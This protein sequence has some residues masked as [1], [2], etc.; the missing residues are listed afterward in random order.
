MMASLAFV[1]G[2]SGGAGP[3]QINPAGPPGIPG[4]PGA[5][6][7]PGLNGVNGKDGAPGLIQSING[8][9]A[10]AI[11]L[12]AN[13]IGAQPAG[14]DASALQLPAPDGASLPATL[15]DRGLR[16]CRAAD[17]GGWGASTADNDRIHQAMLA[18]A[19][20]TGSGAFALEFP[21][22]Q[23][24]LTVART[25]A[26]TKPFK[27]VT[28]GRGT[29]RFLVGTGG[30]SLL[31]LQQQTP[32]AP[33]VV[34]GIEFVATAPGVATPLVLAYAGTP[35]GPS[36]FNQYPTVALRDLAWSGSDHTPTTGLNYFVSPFDLANCWAPVLE[37]LHSTGSVQN[38]FAAQS[39]G[40]L[41][42]CFAAQLREVFGY[43]SNYGLWMPGGATNGQN[44]EGFAYHS[45]EMVG[46]NVGIYAVGTDA[47]PGFYVGPGVHINAAS[48][49]IRTIYKSQIAILSKLLYKLAGD[50]SDFNALDIQKAAYGRISAVQI[51]DSRSSNVGGAFTGLKLTDCIGL[52]V[53]GI[54]AL[55]WQNP[56]GVL[57]YLAGTTDLCE[58]SGIDAR[59]VAGL[60]AVSFDATVGKGN[61]FSRVRPAIEQGLAVNSTTPSVGNDRSGQWFAANTQATP[62]TNFS[63]GYPGQIIYIVPQENNTSFVHNTN[64]RLRA[65][66]GSITNLAGVQISFVRRGAYWWQ[67]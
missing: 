34:E 32:G 3:P 21:A 20:D 52:T 54:E 50:A 63:D 1:S 6:G 31:T 66:S 57:V 15:A 36:P 7:A 10:A 53:D 60:Q 35:Q 49:C 2:N 62:I 51:G 42:Y 4:Q 41:R 44:D 59:K 8:K 55:G 47:D 46:V 9:S 23:S 65:G 45:G 37:R 11:T 48:A 39:S 19:A 14:G 26:T 27:L 43:Y 64:L 5:Q 61:I 13:D 24:P 33:I 29:C 28:P 58:F 56:N 30:Q 40:I 67:I 16:L 12:A 38:Q 22:G 25:L 18:R 17:F